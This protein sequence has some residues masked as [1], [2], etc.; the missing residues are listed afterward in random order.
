MKALIVD[1]E[2][3]ARNKLKILLEEHRQVEI[4]GEAEGVEQAIAL[5]DKYQ[6]DVIFLDIQL[7]GETGFDLLAKADIQSQVIFVTAYDDYA[8]RAFNVNAL[9]YLLK[10]VEP[11]RLAKSLE[12][13]SSESKIIQEEPAK[14]EEQFAYDDNVFIHIDGHLK[15][16]R[17]DSIKYIEAQGY[18]STI[19]YADNQSGFVIKTLKDWEAMLPPKHFV[20]IHRS[21]MINLEY[22]VKTEK[23]FNYTYRVYLKD[24]EEPLIIS[25]RYTVK[26]KRKFRNK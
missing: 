25:R 17:I 2:R 24:V 19:H 22:V 18:A 14:A 20:R 26:L 21:T 10:P 11:E 7:H 4:I 23:W 5:I 16:I 6:P 9:D 15:V 8:I 3:L 12:R 1:D 13:L